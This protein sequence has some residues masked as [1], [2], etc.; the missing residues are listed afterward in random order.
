MKRDRI[1]I[2]HT[3]ETIAILHNCAP[4]TFANYHLNQ[5]GH[6]ISYKIARA[7]NE[8]SDQPVHPR[9]LTRTFAEHSVGSQARAYKM[10]FMLNSAEHEIF[11]AYK[12]ENANKSWH[13][14]IY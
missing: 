13:F 8:D 4:C 14:H 3:T 11:S 6:K 9:S 12:Y 5:P 2:M 1:D 10:F 7:A